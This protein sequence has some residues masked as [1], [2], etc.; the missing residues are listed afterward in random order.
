MFCLPSRLTNASNRC[1]KVPLNIWTGSSLI[2]FRSWNFQIWHK[3][4]L[5]SRYFICHSGQPSLAKQSGCSRMHPPMY[6]APG[7]H[8]SSFI[9][10]YLPIP[11]TSAVTN[12]PNRK[13][14][15][16]VHWLKSPKLVWH[17]FTTVESSHL[18]YKEESDKF[19]WLQQVW[20]VAAAEK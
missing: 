4:R 3:K 7:K 1:I 13:F 11:W 2:K 6:R 19:W 10:K 17:E 18:Y 16:L 9:L 20:S 15:T 12:N 14:I 8:L 5:R